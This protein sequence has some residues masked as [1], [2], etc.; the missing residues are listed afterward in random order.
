MVQKEGPSSLVRLEK[1]EGEPWYKEVVELRKAANDYKVSS[2]R[3]V[4][5]IF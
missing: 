4:R 3:T 5:F 2:M 1:L